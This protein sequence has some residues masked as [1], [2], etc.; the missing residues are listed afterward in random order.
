M[1]VF[2]SNLFNVLICIGF[3]APQIN[4]FYILSIALYSIVS[5]NEFNMFNSKK[6]VFL[7]LSVAVIFLLSLALSWLDIGFYFNNDIIKPLL[8]LILIYNLNDH[9]VKYV[10]NA[11]L[12]YLLFILLLVTQLAYVL[13]FE[14]IKTVIDKFYPFD[15]SQV[16]WT[17]RSVYDI[18]IANNF[19]IRAGGIYRNPNQY[20]KYINLLYIVFLSSTGFEKKSHISF[21]L[22]TF[23]TILLTGSRTGLLVFILI[24]L[25]YY[26]K[27]NVGKIFIFVAGLGMLYIASQ[28]DLRVFDILSELSGKGSLTH[29]Q[30]GLDY[31]M[32][33]TSLWELFFGHYYN[34]ITIN[35]LRQGQL[36]FDGDLISSLFSYGIIGLSILYLLYYRI[37]RKNKQLLLLPIFLYGVTGGLLQDLNFIILL[38]TIISCQELNIGNE[39]R[40][41]SY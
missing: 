26:R 31:L 20:A 34:E 16:V 19:Q 2:N 10:L 21:S 37:I 12:I 30:A 39:N 24:S 8:I 17:H 36:M 25:L 11:K 28:V 9:G 29:R 40:K 18:D 7:K 23:L 41:L 35:T 14:F 33:N 32:N 38:S 5:R 27:F 22:L 4:V 1:R 15:E 6:T 3:I 13:N